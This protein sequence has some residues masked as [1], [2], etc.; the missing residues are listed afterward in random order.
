MTAKC[1]MP[2]VLRKGF[3]ISQNCLRFV[4]KLAADCCISDFIVYCMSLRNFRNCS[5][6]LRALNLATI[7]AKE[8]NLEYSRVHACNS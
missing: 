6:Y 5:A 4:M 8:H 7:R 2:H 1:K 3:D